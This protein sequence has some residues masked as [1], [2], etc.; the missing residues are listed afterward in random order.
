MSSCMSL[1]TVEGAIKLS[2]SLLVVH[3]WLGRDQYKLYWS[4]SFELTLTSTIHQDLKL[5]SNAEV[6]ETHFTHNGRRLQW[7][8]GDV[9]DA[10]C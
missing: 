3:V 5:K 10:E 8:R 7:N 9:K 2:V 4:E 6:D 1:S